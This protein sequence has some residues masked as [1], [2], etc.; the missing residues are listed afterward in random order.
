MA[1]LW[2]A[3]CTIRVGFLDDLA[4]A[5]DRAPTGAS[6]GTPYVVAALGQAVVGLRRV[7]ATAMTNGLAVPAM[8]SAVTFF[9]GMTTGR[10]AAALVQAQPDYFGAH[11]YERVDAE[12]GQFRGAQLL[13]RRAVGNR[14]GQRHASSSRGNRRHDGRRPRPG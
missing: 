13:R 11:T 9:D 14:A 4:D 1:R 10:S 12:R 8:A 6:L 7:A 5:L 3:G 2:R